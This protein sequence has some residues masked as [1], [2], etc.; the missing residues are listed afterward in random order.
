MSAEHRIELRPGY[1]FVWQRGG[2]DDLDEARV[3]QRE[4]EAALRRHG[5]RKVLIDNRETDLPDEQMRAFMNAWSEN[6]EIFDAMAI[7]VQSTMVK[8]RSTM[9]AIAH[10]AMRRA[11]NSIE[12]AEAWLLS[13]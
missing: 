3:F 10:G 1:V 12:E 5:V 6:R 2:M 7:V 4:V 11:F 8:V 9:E 13:R